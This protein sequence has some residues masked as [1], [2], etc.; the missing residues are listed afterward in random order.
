MTAPQ[1]LSMKRS[2]VLTLAGLFVFILYLYFF[3]GFGDIL[4]VLTEVNLADYLFYYSLA[5]A[6][7]LLGIF[8]Y[9]MTWYELLRILS[10]K[11]S[12]RKA[13]IYCWLGGFVDLVVPAEAVTGEITRVYLATRD[14]TEHVG[15]IV[16]SLI[17]QRILSTMAV[18]GSLIIGSV[19]LA[20]RYEVHQDVLNLLT[21]VQI[22]TASS[23]VLILY[24]SVKKGA[25]ERILDS[26]LKLANFIFKGRLK[27]ADLR[28]RAHRALGSFYQ[29]ID[30]IVS[31][32]R[33][34]IKPILF[35]FASWFFHLAIYS[36]VFYALGLEISLEVSII[37]Y[38]ITVAVQTVPI[39]LPVGLVEV[40]MLNLYNIFGILPAASGTATAL[41]RVVTFWFQII[42]GYVMAQWIGINTLVQRKAS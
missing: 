25:A 27:L 20:F 22:V 32:P 12:L 4:R 36:L 26:L 9:S 31:R 30:V 23:I 17:S 3:V 5:F 35:N 29:G 18:L 8:F 10:V 40:V 38:S 41:I 15:R 2:I 11:M 39:G 7:V 14:S 34:L 13:F 19:S 1:G 24:F 6:A 21:A 16:A 42:V 37:V 33:S 28:T